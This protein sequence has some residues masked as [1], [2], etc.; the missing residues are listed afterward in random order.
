MDWKQALAAIRKV[1]TGLKL[2][3]G[4]MADVKHGEGD[5]AKS[6]DE[7]L[8]TLETSLTAGATSADGN[9]AQVVK[10][11][12]ERDALKTERDEL[13]GKVASAGDVDA[14]VAAAEGKAT[15]ATERAI[16]A[17]GSLRGL[18]VKS[19]ARD[20]LDSAGLPPAQKKTALALLM[21]DVSDVE[22]D[23][24]GAVSGLKAKLAGLKTEHP[25]LWTAPK[26]GAEGD[27]GG[28]AGGTGNAGAGSGASDG[29]G[30][31]GT[32]DDNAAFEAQLSAAMGI[33]P[34]AGGNANQAA[35]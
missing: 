9:A 15:K 25:H 19:A 2:T 11:T 32:G 27:G 22:V 29:K 3:D 33:K 14:R 21:L 10:L 30:M 4:T 24:E 8:G 16:S 23:A 26:T 20:A 1:L 28:D 7:L 6:I 12:N 5:E 35:A 13:A 34:D 31:A 18:S 17:E